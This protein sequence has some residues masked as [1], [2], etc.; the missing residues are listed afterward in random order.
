MV[1]ARLDIDILAGAVHTSDCLSEWTTLIGREAPDPALI[2]RE[3]YRTEI[4]S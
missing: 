4:F 3:L 2:G 1:R